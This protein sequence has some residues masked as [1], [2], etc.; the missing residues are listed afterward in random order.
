MF[1]IL[2]FAGCNK[3]EHPV[4]NVTFQASFDLMLPQFSGQVFVARRDGF[5]NL[6]GYAGIIVFRNGH[7]DYSAFERLCPFDA[8]AGCIVTPDE[9][10]MMASCNC[11]RSRYLISSPFGADVVTGPATIPLKQYRTRIERGHI[12]VVYN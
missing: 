9:G 10:N 8:K 5:G 12:L 11:C 4:P 7:L 2:F 1:V 6:A 3:N